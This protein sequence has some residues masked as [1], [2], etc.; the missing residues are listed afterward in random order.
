MQQ[1]KRSEGETVALIAV[2]I[3]LVALSID[4]MLPALPA[5]GDDLGV[6]RDNDRQQVIT[7]F[8]LGLGIGQMIYGPLSDSTGRKPAIYAG[9][10][11]FMAG[12]LISAFAQSFEMMLLG[13][14]L[15][16]FGAAGP[17]IVVVAMVRDQYAGAAMAR[18]M[19]V[20]M[21]V[22]ILVP[23]LAPAVGQGIVI[24]WHW[25]GVFAVFFAIAVIGMIWMALRQP[26]TLPP[27]ARRAF[28]AAVL[29]RKVA[30][31][32]RNRVAFGY[33]MA[34]GLIF[35]AFVGYLTSTEQIFHDI[36]HLGG[37]F[38]IYFAVL[39]LFIGAASL[40]NAR[41][42]T[43]FGMT[44]LSRW[45][46]VTMVVVCGVF[47]GFALLWDGVP[48]LWSYMVCYAISFF[49]IGMLFG[50]LN[51]LAMEPMGHIAGTAATVI[52]SMT[53]L[54]SLIF[55]TVIGAMFDGTV[56]PVS[57]GFAGL[58]LAAL[59]VAEWTEAGRDR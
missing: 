27:E 45:A 54:M 53:T 58:G 28:S 39:A 16:G 31:V 52:G 37:L 34:A 10:V 38:P 59:L 51:A 11:L 49:A 9:L 22:F 21:A 8:L 48:P 36:Y 55:G 2:L 1:I 3:C 23:A 33:M 20:V 44:R 15:Q 41:L 7:V 5:I 14:A 13:R 46:L 6:P 25:R 43:R 29:G 17:R 50:N 42:V 12:S 35:G 40:A 24:I 4:A 47:S 56:V 30:E 26:E 57:I 18:I 19:S 32:F